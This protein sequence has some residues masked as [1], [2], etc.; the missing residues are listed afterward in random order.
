MTFPTGHQGLTAYRELR[1]FRKRHE[2]EWTYEQLNARTRLKAGER[3]RDQKANS[4]ADLAAVLETQ[5]QIAQKHQEQADRENKQKANATANANTRYQ[6][7]GVRMRELRSEALSGNEDARKEYKQLK[8]E[9]IHIRKALRKPMP[10]L[11][12]KRKY[13]PL[14][15]PTPVSQRRFT[16]EQRQKL[17]P[18]MSM[19]GL[20]IQWANTLDAE[21]ARTWPK[22]VVHEALQ[23]ANLRTRHMHPPTA[24][25]STNLDLEA[26]ENSKAQATLQESSQPET[27]REPSMLERL[28][29][30]LRDGAN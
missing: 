12:L 30:R 13:H 15:D 6:E 29:V 26:I 27:T 2:H 11:A 1:E 18:R 28:V 14:N 19:A 5:A 23:E 17:L 3:L 7:I 22:S 20:R 4:I 10:H 9:K 24:A 16:R 25:P 8:N 21:F